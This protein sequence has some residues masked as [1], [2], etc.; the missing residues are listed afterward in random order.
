M[1][2]G[3]ATVETARL[4][5]IDGGGVYGA[6]ID[7]TWFTTKG[8]GAITDERGS[9]TIDRL[10]AIGRSSLVAHKSTTHSPWSATTATF[11]RPTLLRNKF[12]TCTAYSTNKWW[13][14][15]Q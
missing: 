7:G 9:L 5:A 12:D 8:R 4:Y 10:A 11:A 1:T 2:G 15:A 3:L 6:T 14:E 13:F